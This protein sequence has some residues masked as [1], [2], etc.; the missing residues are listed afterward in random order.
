MDMKISYFYHFDLY[1]IIVNSV[2]ESFQFAS[3]STYLIS[4]Q[5]LLFIRS[6]GLPVMSMLRN[7]VMVTV[8]SF[9]FQVP[10]DQ[11]DAL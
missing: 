6:I 3:L 7:I 5:S 8:S 2:L 4:A 9:E 1:S 10:I 11:F